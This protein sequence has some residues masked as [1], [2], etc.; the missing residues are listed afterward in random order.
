MILTDPISFWN[1]VSIKLINTKR[2][3]IDNTECSK[4]F[5]KLI[6]R[7]I[8]VLKTSSNINEANNSFKC[9]GIFNFNLIN[10]SLFFAPIIYQ[11][12]VAFSYKLWN[13]FNPQPLSQLSYYVAY[14]Q[15]RD[16][17]YQTPYQQMS[18]NLSNYSQSYGQSLMTR[19]ATPNQNIDRLMRSKCS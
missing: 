6:N 9:F 10:L 4:R 2:R 16:N 15:T 7:F 14:D 1:I 5:Q 11:M 8:N 13:G 12:V 19:E 3:Q 17:Y 18:T